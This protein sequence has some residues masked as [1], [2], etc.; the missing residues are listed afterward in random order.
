MMNWWQNM[1]PRERILIGVAVILTVIIVAWQF[2]FMPTMNARDEARAN[3]DEADRVLSQ[4]Q[5]NY[6]FKRAQGAASANNARAT[7][8][9]IEDFTL[10]HCRDQPER[11]AYITCLLH[12]L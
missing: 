10:R 11:V 7:S 12:S 5:E 8:G 6:V 2:V 3:L 9:N 4:I 1:A